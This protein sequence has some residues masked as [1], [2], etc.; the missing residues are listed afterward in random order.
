MKKKDK[1]QR[2]ESGGHSKSGGEG[3]EPGGERQDD[4]GSKRAPVSGSG[5]QD[6]DVSQA[7]VATQD[8]MVEPA[9]K[10]GSGDEHGEEISAEETKKLYSEVK[11]LAPELLAQ[12]QKTGLTFLKMGHLLYRL[13]GGKR[14]F[15]D[16]GYGSFEKI[17]EGSGFSASL[18]YQMRSMYRWFVVE[19]RLNSE[20][21]QAVMALPKAQQCILLGRLTR[22]NADE[23]VAKA[24]RTSPDLF[25]AFVDTKFGKRKTKKGAD[26]RTGRKPTSSKTEKTEVGKAH[27]EEVE[28]PAARPAEAELPA[29]KAAATPT[30]STGTTVDAVIE[31]ANKGSVGVAQ[32]AIVLAKLMTG[33]DDEEKALTEVFASYL[34]QFG[35]VEPEQYLQEWLESRAG[36]QVIIVRDGKVVYGERIARRLS[37]KD[38]GSIV[39]GEAD[40]E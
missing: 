6:G 35:E 38:D 2:S 34:H 39:V 24:K 22:E 1:G 8:A 20:Q 11:A 4:A 37:V 28:Q 18:G 32:K 27:A 25:K 3:Q 9:A 17:C 13:T 15:T 29:G 19:A 36:V 33:T 5:M 40:A 30:T 7:L 31:S 26:K 12:L 14:Y 16:L 23:L 10:D 21:L